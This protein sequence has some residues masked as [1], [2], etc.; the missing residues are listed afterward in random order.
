MEVEPYFYWD[1]SLRTKDGLSLQECL[2]RF[3]TGVQQAS[4]F[5]Y[6]VVFLDESK[7]FGNSFMLWARH[8]VT[9]Q[10]CYV[11]LYEKNPANI[12]MGVI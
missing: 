6:K 10:N 11:R 9:H 12:R 3:G 7:S 5:Y 8:N 1:D 4:Q 2:E